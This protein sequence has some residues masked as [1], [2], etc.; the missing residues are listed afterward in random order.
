MAGTG[1]N[2]VSMNVLTLF[3]K[4]KIELFLYIINDI[5]CI[6]YLN[7]KGRKQSL[8]MLFSFYINIEKVIYSI[9]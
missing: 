2:D 4:S 7:L 6:S 8:K 9:K 5:N 1:T 3:G